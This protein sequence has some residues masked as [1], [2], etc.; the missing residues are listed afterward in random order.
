MT[1]TEIALIIG[2]LAAFAT[3]IGGI[4]LNANRMEKLREENKNNR[5]ANAHNRES[6]IRIGEQLALTRAD[7]AQLALLVNQLFN[8]YKVATGQ[9]PPIDWDMF[10]KMMS[11][12]YITGPLGP[13]NRGTRT[14]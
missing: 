1:G 2:S 7:N 14:E 8:Q 11:L 9:D 12:K 13:L 10:D 3:A 4:L 6:I 5:L